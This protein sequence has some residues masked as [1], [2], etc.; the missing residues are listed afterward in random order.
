ME[1][2]KISV[3]NYETAR[4]FFTTSSLGTD[5]RHETSFPKLK[6]FLAKEF[7][8]KK[9]GNMILWSPA[10]FALMISLWSAGSVTNIR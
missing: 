5:Y 9:Y 3:L 6:E 7:M 10:S 8:H 2:R 4:I 1:N